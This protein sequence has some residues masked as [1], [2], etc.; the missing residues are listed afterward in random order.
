MTETH[1]PEIG[2]RL[3]VSFP[4]SG[5]QPDWE[6]VVARASGRRRRLQMPVSLRLRR[7]LVLVPLLAVLAGAG[8]ALAV[9]LTRSGGPATWQLI[10]DDFVSDGHLNHR[11]SCSDLAT[12]E[13]KLG[14]HFPT[15]A[16][17]IKRETAR[18]CAR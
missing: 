2:K 7:T 13:S 1:D 3:S 9:K 6:A 15:L 14:P 5:S 18:R 8:T 16:A 11:Y 12:A 4:A 10:I 17:Q